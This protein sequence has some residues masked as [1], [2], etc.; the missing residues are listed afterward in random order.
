MC[1]LIVVDNGLIYVV[2]SSRVR[3]VSSKV[4]YDT[5]VGLVKVLLDLLKLYFRV[6]RYLM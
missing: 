6:K 5:R 4:T 1:L 3:Q 2:R